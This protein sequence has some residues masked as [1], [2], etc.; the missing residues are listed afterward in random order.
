MRVTSKTLTD[1]RVVS[2]RRSLA[3]HFRGIDAD[4]DLIVETGYAPAGDDANFLYVLTPC[5]QVRGKWPLDPRDERVF[6]IRIGARHRRFPSKV[7]VCRRCLNE[8]D[9]KHGYEFPVADI[10]VAVAA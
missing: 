1:G 3:K 6:L 2:V 8:V 9:R 5:C 10:A 7:V 4:G